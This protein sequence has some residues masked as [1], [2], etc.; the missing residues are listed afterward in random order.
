VIGESFDEICILNLHGSSRIG[1][2]TPEYGREIFSR[3]KRGFPMD[4]A[5]FEAIE[6]FKRALEYQGIRVKKIILYGSQATGKAGEHSDIDIVVISDDF[7]GINLLE[8]LEI[9][10]VAMARARIFKPIEPL[11]YTEEEFDAKGR[12]T[13]VGD[14]VKE[15]GIEVL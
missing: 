2:K 12:G 6:E 9:L 13:F 11:G 15:M 1:E 5:V 7:E 3:S 8:R 4:K 14:E 10:G